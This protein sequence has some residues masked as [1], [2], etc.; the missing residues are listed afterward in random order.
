MQ[1]CQVCGKPATY[2]MKT[3]IN[4][5][6]KT[7]AL[8]SECAAKQNTD[9][10]K[11][12]FDSLAG[13]FGPFFLGNSTP[14]AE[15]KRCPTCG[16]V[17]KQISDSS[18]F[19]CPD[20]YKTFRKESEHSLKKIHSDLTHKGKTPRSVPVKPENEIEKLKAQLAQAVAVENYERAAEL[21]DKI[22][23]LTDEKEGK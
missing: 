22:K 19:G 21:R 4:G 14:E 3:N 15:I 16:T 10:F 17:F 9:V 6:V 1:K 12:H 2:V 23:L 20:C 7:L 11:S 13:F 8:C 5:E 18:R